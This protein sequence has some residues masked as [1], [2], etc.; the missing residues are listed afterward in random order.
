[1]ASSNKTAASSCSRAA[2][3]RTAAGLSL[4][5]A[6]ADEQGGGRGDGDAGVTVL[7]VADS[8]EGTGDELGSDDGGT[9]GVKLDAGAGEGPSG[10]CDPDSVDM[11]GMEELSYI[12]IANS[13][14]GTVSKIDTRTRVELARYYTGPSMADD[15][16]RTS[17]NLRGDVA[18]AN[19]NG[20]IVKFASEL[21]RCVDRNG[22]GTIET[23]SGPGD[24]LLWADEECH[25]W[26]RDIAV[27][28]GMPTLDSANTQG[29]RPTAWDLG[30]HLDPCSDDHR[31]WVG[32]FSAAQ[33]RMHLLRLDG[34]TGAILDVIESPWQSGLL[35]GYGPYGGAVDPENAMWVLGLGGPVARVDPVTLEVERWDTPAGLQ[36]YGIAIDHEG[37]PWFATLTGQVVHFDPQTA[38]FD[39][40]PATTA[41]LRGLQVDRDGVVWAAHGVPGGGLGCGLVAVDVATRSLI[42]G[43]IPLPGCVEPVGV[44]I[45]VDGFVWLPDKGANGAFKVDP[46]THTTELVGGLTAPYTYSDMTGSGL[47]LVAFP[48]TG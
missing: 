25:L 37:D 5:L 28:P 47:A 48:P 27:D 1:M 16:S 4:V 39:V 36:P 45:D 3:A 34:K 46:V 9:S 31:V 26:H 43:A 21:D 41:G 35:A 42:D 44:S 14:E 32:W 18:I 22:N 12:W 7:T 29:P 8:G 2:L 6:C 23:S 11:G 15:P 10:G 38:S 13:P 19:R 30:E 20:G 17:V 24:V 33:Q 40:I